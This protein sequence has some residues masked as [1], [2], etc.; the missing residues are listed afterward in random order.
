MTPDLIGIFVVV[1]LAL[2]IIFRGVFHLAVFISGLVVSVQFFFMIPD[3][4]EILVGLK[5]MFTVFFV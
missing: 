5:T 1:Q 4:T 2:K 3:S